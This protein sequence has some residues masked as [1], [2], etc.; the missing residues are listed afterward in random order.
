[1]RCACFNCVI[2]YD[3]ITFW[4]VGWLRRDQLNSLSGDNRDRSAMRE[5]VFR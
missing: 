2:M 3:L 1:M 5:K 4:G